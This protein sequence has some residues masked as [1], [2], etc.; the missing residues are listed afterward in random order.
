MKRIYVAGSY[1]ADNT[2]Q[3]LQNIGIG[4]KTCGKLFQLGY[5]PFCPW[6]DRDYILQSPDLDFDVKQFHDHSMAWLEVADA[7][8]VISGQGKGGGVDAEIK[9][10]HEIGISVFFDIDDLMAF[11]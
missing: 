7:L 3:T 11:D 10:A 8:Y 9:R 6:S 1:S 4:L 2:I 5:A